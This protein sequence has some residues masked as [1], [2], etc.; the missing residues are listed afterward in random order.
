MYRHMKVHRSHTH[1]T[2]CTLGREREGGRKGGRGKGREGRGERKREGVR[3]GRRGRGREGEDGG[4]VYYVCGHP[5]RNKVCACTGTREWSIDHTPQCTH[6]REG[7]GGRGRE[8]EGERDRGE[9]GEGRGGG[10]GEIH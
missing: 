6:G 10:G 4:K 3:E 9:V 8:R 1:Y 5:M 7:E 2:P